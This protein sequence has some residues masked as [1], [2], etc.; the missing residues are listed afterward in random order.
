MG[1]VIPYSKLSYKL[2]VLKMFHVRDAF[3]RT[4]RVDMDVMGIEMS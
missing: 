1:K 4:T 2:Q 3:S